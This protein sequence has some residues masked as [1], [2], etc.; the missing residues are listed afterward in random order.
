VATTASGLAFSRITH[1]FN[2]TVN[3]TNIGIGPINGPFSIVFTE[4]TAGVTLAN[5]TGNLSGSPFLTVP[6]ASLAAGQST[7]V[8]VRFDDPSFGMINFTPVIYSGSI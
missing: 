6:V 3:L 4:L 7:T 8:N 2:G 5:A 1:T